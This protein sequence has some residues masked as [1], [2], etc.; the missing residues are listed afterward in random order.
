MVEK[1]KLQQYVDLEDNVLTTK[2]HEVICSPHRHDSYE[3]FLNVV[4][5]TIKDA[6]NL[7]YGQFSLF[8]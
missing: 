1:V 4:N 5:S 8:I 3:H 6:I 2:M 7:L